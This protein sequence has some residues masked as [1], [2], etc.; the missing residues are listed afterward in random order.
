M[1]SVKLPRFTAPLPARLPNVRPP[2]NT[3]VAAPATAA[4][5]AAVRRFAPASVSVP[6]FTASV[7]AADV[8]LSRLVPLEVRLPPPRL[9]V[10]MPL[11][12]A[13]LLALSVL[14]LPGLLPSVPV[15]TSEAM[16]T[17]PA[18]VIEAPLRTTT[19]AV[20]AS[21]SAPVSTR[22]PPFTSSVCEASVPASVS[23]P[24]STRVLPA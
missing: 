5:G 16:L 4:A 8:P 10:T 7:M 6:P 11:S 2:C 3:S 19:A 18:S 21:R 1:L 15:R 23:V 14:V 20:L 13:T 12:S 24:A 9:A 22:L 17:S